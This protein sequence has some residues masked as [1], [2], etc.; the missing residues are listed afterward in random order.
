MSYSLNPREASLRGRIGAYALHATH[1]PRETTRAARE[2]FLSKFEREVDPDGVLPEPERLRRAEAAKKA[3][4]ARLAL[5]S[6]RKR[7]Q[8]K[9]KAAVDQTATLDDPE[10]SRDDSTLNVP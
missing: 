3:H 1:D 6:A 5:A 2:Q 8:G 7:S 10:V 4:F 9:K